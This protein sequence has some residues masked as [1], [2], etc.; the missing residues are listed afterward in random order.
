M[1]R[2]KAGLYLRLSKDDGTG[3]SSSIASQRSILRSFARENGID[4][5]D[6]YT[7]DGYSGTNFSR[8]EFERM[9]HDVEAG[10]INTVLVKDLSR[11][12]RNSARTSDLLDEYFP[13][14][15]IRFVSV[16]DGYDSEKLSCGMAMAAPLM[17]AVHE[18]Y[19]RDTS[20]KIRSAFR[21][22][23]K[24]GKYIGSF[25]PYGYL[26]SPNDKNILI[27]NNETAPIVAEIFL[28]A[29]SLVPAAVA[30]ILNSRCISSPLEYR[31]TGRVFTECPKWTASSVNKI[32]RNPV[33]TGD[34]VQGKTTKVS[35]KS[36]ETREKPREEW[37]VYPNAHEAIVSRCLFEKVQEIRRRRK[38]GG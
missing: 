16:N 4:V 33:Y 5:A 25:A 20:N 12:G 3:E 6:E 35:F 1:S 2:Y 21:E 17:M 30:D 18:M 23:M 15:N 31:R 14:K 8:P 36:K 13:R 11:L 38:T 24:E 27:I 28:L 26:K 9:I 19:A 10:V 34:M 37:V 7:D 29:V 22:K 32:L